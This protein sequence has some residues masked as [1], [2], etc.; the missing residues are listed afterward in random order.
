MTVV[1]A[2]LCDAVNPKG[3]ALYYS[4]SLFLEYMESLLKI[5]KLAA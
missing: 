2:V 5:P 4:P 1:A 3:H